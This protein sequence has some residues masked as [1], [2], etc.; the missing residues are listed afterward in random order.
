MSSIPCDLAIPLLMVY[1]YQVVRGGTEQ[2]I[3]AREIV[4]GDIAIVEEGQTVPA[5]GK[6][7]I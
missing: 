4:A 3:A 2:E 6:A 1:V 5:D 7:C